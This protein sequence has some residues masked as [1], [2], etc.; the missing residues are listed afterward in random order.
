MFTSV[1]FLSD[2]KA[3]ETIRN[4]ALS[5]KLS[6]SVSLA[7]TFPSYNPNPE[8]G[9]LLYFICSTMPETVEEHRPMMVDYIATNRLA[10]QAQ[11]TTAINFLKKNKYEQAL[12]DETCGV[13]VEVTEDQI[14]TCVQTLISADK[15][16][17]AK[18][19]WTS[20]KY[21]GMLMGK[22]LK[23]FKWANTQ[24]IKDVV[25][26]ELVALNGPKPDKIEVVKTKQPKN[27]KEKKKKMLS[28]CSGR[29]L[30]SAVNS[31]ENM[32]K[33]LAFT[34]GKVMTRFPPEPNGY[35]HIGH[36]KAICFNFRVAAEEGGHCYLRFDDTNP[37]R[38]TQEFIDNIQENVR[39]L[40]YEPWKV[41]HASDYFEEMYELG[42][43][44][45]R[46]GKGYIDLQPKENIKA[47]RKKKEDSP[48]RETSIEE[49]LKLFDLMRKGYYDEAEACMRMK[50][51]MK[52]TNPCMRD[53]VAFRIKYKPHP[54]AGDKWCLYPTYDMEHCI[55][56]S[57]ENITHSLCTLEF[58]IR[59]DSYYWL[60]DALDIFK[61]QVW[62]YSRLNLTNAVIS[63][64]KLQVLVDNNYVNGW[65]DPRLITLNGLRRRG[66]TKEAVNN[67]I[68]EIGVT[69]RGNDK[70]VSIGL[71]EMHLARELDKSAPRVMVIADPYKITITNFGEPTTQEIAL[72]PKQQEKGN[73]SITLTNT[74]FIEK[75]D[76]QDEKD[77]AFWG[78]APGQDVGL[79]YCNAILKFIERNGDEIK[80]EV[81]QT[82]EKPKQYIHWISDA[83]SMCVELRLYDHLFTS[84]YPNDSENWLDEFNPNSLVVVPTARFPVGMKDRLVPEAHFQFERNGYYVVDKD[85]TPDQVVL[86][87]S[88]K[89]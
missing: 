41:T 74:I 9:K 30:K 19:G 89:L 1:I 47:Q 87:R 34:G 20:A 32:K 53:P 82:E 84:K 14:R 29:E 69:R 17:I 39:W 44:L 26:Q 78:L 25:L 54:H 27:T 57:L 67:F 3:D 46:R 62:E 71:L 79:K 7:R 70:F 55:V 68:D 33:H 75:K 80:V 36:A 61:S 86:N 66:Y 85:T 6:E 12:F 37:D 23:E 72:F 35:L 42:C 10:S 48:Y 56:D 49:N 11:V 59:R 24:L 64:R 52:H 38:E 22:V 76:F 21:E 81:V 8:N 60:V 5:A 18:T 16:A 73:R 58:E 83:D 40:G 65:D 4:K 13:G 50:I 45:I 28:E 77:E 15:E 31:E 43:E 51:D 2:S 63:K 88:L